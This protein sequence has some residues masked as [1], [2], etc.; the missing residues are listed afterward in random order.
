VL[1]QDVVRDVE[2]EWFALLV[3]RAMFTKRGTAFQDFFAELMEAAH[4]GDFERVR[5][6]GNQG[7]RKCDGILRSRGTLFQVYAPR[8][9][10]QAE[11]VAKIKED[12]GGA[13][14]HW[15]AEMRGWIFVHNDLE[16]LPPEVV[17]TIDAMRRRHKAVAIETWGPD[18]LQTIALGLPR[19]K[20]V[21]MFGR[22]PQRQ[23]FER[24]SFRPLAKVLSAIIGHAPGQLDAIE[25]VSPKK[26]E[27]TALGAAA[28][29][30]LKLGRQRE[31]LVQQY[32]ETH[33][34]PTLGEEIATAFRDEYRR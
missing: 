21:L 7:D 33:P 32:L 19:D 25:P 15:K 1:G 14:Q 2:L 12:F 22:P 29:D 16:G 31:H 20:L 9:T 26:L 5:P 13:K 27:A 3:Q 11:M 34:N 30:Y 8:E 23:D 10:K 28:V 24:L 18:R 4:P 6:Y 17:K